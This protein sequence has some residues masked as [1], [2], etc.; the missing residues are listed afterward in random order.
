MYK[1]VTLQKNNLSKFGILPDMKVGKKRKK[2]PSIF[3]LPVGTYHKNQKIR[4]YYYYF[5]PKSG[6]FMP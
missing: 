4:N 2:D 1:V 6:K 3:L 5:P